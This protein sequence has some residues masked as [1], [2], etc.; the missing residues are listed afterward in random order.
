MIVFQC[1]QFS[2]HSRNPAR[3]HASLGVRSGF[4]CSRY[5]VDVGLMLGGDVSVGNIVLDWVGGGDS[6]IALEI[7]QTSWLLSCSIGSSK[8]GR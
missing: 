1:C 7:Q 3:F 6:F 8:D 5:R 4:R 2:L